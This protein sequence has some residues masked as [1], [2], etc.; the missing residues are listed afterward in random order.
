[1]SGHL[2]ETLKNGIKC[3]FGIFS[4]HISFQLDSPWSLFYFVPKESHRH[5]LSGLA[6]FNLY[7]QDQLIQQH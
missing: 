7:A 3:Q 5:R 1:M 6:T 2:A 4:Y